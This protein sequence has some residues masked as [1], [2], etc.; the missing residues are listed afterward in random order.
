MAHGL[1]T[2]MVYLV[3]T[4]KNEIEPNND[5][6]SKA[7]SLGIFTGTIEIL[8]MPDGQIMIR[9]LEWFLLKS[10]VKGFV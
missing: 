2:S 4:K 8:K 9:N 10:L 1:T 7:Q 5:D 6:V 3:D